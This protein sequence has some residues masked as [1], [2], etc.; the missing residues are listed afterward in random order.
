MHKSGLY[1]IFVIALYGLAL[2]NIVPSWGMYIPLALAFIPAF[3]HAIKELKNK[4]IGSEIFL[5][6]ATI[7]GLIGHEEQAIT[8]VLIIMLIAEYLEDL[9]AGRTE[10]A[11]KSLVTLIPTNVIARVNDQ[12]VD[13]PIKKV[14]PGMLLIIKTGKRIPVDG[15]VQEGT[16]VVN[17]SALTGESILKEKESGSKVYAGTFIDAGSIVIKVEKVAGDTFFGKISSMVED[18]QEVKAKIA[19]YADTFAR[20]L[21]P[22]MLV[23]IGAVWIITRDTSLVVTLLV[24]GSPLELTLITP[25]AVLAGIAA[26]F[27]HG[28]LVKGGLSLERFSSIDIMAFDKTGTLTMGE[29]ELK[30]IEIF[31]NSFSYREVLRI[32]AIAQKRAD[33]VAS[34]AVLKK[35]AQM[36]IEVPDPQTYTSE[37]GHGVEVMI[38]NKK[39]FLGNRHYIEAPEHGN[40]VFHSKKETE[41]SFSSFYL[42]SMQDGLIAKLFMADQVRVEAKDTIAQLRAKVNTL[43]KELG[44][45]Q[46]FGGLFPDQKI[47]MVKK[48][49]AQGA[50][51]AMVGDGINDAPALKAAHV[52]IAMGAMG[53]E[54]AIEAA[55]IVL[56]TNDLSRI[57][58]VYDLS[59]ATLKVI[60]QNIFVGFVAIHIVGITLAFLRVI[61]PIQA[62]LFHA[63]PDLM[64]LVNSVRLI[65]FK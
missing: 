50:K 39:Y 17:E 47:E 16:A 30:N 28:I 25:L 22:S 13:M 54:P 56:M 11:I 52:G 24:F 7:V 33:H 1:I 45:D 23:F 31:N 61:T 60:K 15:I 51:V 29:P 14:T 46:A 57:V 27:R 36:G 12:E 6:V 35:A 38:D 8:T 10:L 41:S 4:K 64:I 37:V 2:F 34:K 42:A 48:L 9:I 49:Q 62:A 5:V 58:Y 55:D 18:A 21:I 53:M 32:A 44:I 20:I 65:R 43:A 40:I 19:T 3:I 59:R 63:V 26:A